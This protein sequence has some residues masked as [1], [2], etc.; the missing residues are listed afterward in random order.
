MQAGAIHQNELALPRRD[1][2]VILQCHRPLLTA[3]W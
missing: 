3:P 2:I 1:W